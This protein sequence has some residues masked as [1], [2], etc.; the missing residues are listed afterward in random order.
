MRSVMVE[1]VFRALWVA[2]EE[3]R[4]RIDSEAVLAWGRR[5]AVACAAD[6]AA[7]PDY[8]PEADNRVLW[9]REVLQAA[10]RR[11]PACRASG[12]LEAMVDFLLGVATVPVPCGKDLAAGGRFDD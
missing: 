9:T 7:N 12:E 8:T 6:V 5:V 1:E 10:R 4:G 2:R 11:E 3:S